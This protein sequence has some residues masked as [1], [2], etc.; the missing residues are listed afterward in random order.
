M[1]ACGVVECCKMIRFMVMKIWVSWI[2]VKSVIDVF[3][4]E[5]F[6]FEVLGIVL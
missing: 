4:M 6:P 5:L 2:C 1:W 3:I